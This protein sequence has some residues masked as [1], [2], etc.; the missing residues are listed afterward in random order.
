MQN[1]VTLNTCYNTTCL[2]FQLPHI[3]TGSFQSIQ[4]LIKRNKPLVRKKFCNSQVS[5][6][7]FS[8]GVGEW[9]TDCFLVR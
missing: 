1:V 7:S 2:T 8:G 6:V 9:I 5:V 4:R 3:T